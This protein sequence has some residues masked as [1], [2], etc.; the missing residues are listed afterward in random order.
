MNSFMAF[1]YAIKLFYL[2][3]K[4]KNLTLI[5][6]V[7]FL[8]GLK[9]SLLLRNLLRLPRIRHGDPSMKELH[10]KTKVTALRRS[11]EQVSFLLNGKNMDRQQMKS[12]EKKR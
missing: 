11:N 1:R 12:K 8:N 6:T 10:E 4:I 7:T 5:S 3:Q 9:D 2:S